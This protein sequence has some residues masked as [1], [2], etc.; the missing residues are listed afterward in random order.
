MSLFNRNGVIALPGLDPKSGLPDFGT[1]NDRN[2]KRPISIGNPVSPGRWLLAK[3][4]GDKTER[5][6]TISAPPVRRPIA[7]C[8]IWPIRS[9]LIRPP[10][11]RLQERTCWQALYQ[12]GPPP[13]SAQEKRPRGR[14]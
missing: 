3:A 7:C 6:S 8:M 10:P 1:L 14:P 5:N 2:R 9:P 12:A 13:S 11:V 4:V